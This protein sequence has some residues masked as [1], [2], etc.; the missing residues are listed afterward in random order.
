MSGG[1]KE[2]VSGAECGE[3][4]ARVWPP[5]SQLAYETRRE[6]LPISYLSGLRG[7]AAAE[8]DYGLA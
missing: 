5:G 2:G 8:F 1:V 4:R 7:S 6:A 3:K